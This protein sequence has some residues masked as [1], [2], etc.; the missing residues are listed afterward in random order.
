M[1]LEPTS[2]MRQHLTKYVWFV[3]TRPVIHWVTKRVNK[4][5][6]PSRHGLVYLDE[7][8]VQLTTLLELL[9]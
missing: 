3:T 2:V 8:L 5:A 1:S 6:M 4:R 9:S 7:E